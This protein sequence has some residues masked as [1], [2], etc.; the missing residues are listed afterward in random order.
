MK[1]IIVILICV[2]VCCSLLCQ[3]V[4]AAF[5][6]ATYVLRSC[7][8]D[9]ILAYYPGGY[10]Q[11][12]NPGNLQVDILEGHAAVMSFDPVYFDEQVLNDFTFAVNASVSG[13]W[14]GNIPYGQFGYLNFYITY[15]SNLDLNFSDLLNVPIEVYDVYTDLTYTDYAIAEVSS[16]SYMLTFIVDTSDETFGYYVDDNFDHSYVLTLPI[17]PIYSESDSNGFVS[18]SS[19]VL[20]FQ[21]KLSDTIPSSGGTTD[22]DNPDNPETPDIEYEGV[23][24]QSI[25]RGNQLLEEVI[26]NQDTELAFLAV[27]QKIL[28]DISNTTDSIYEGVNDLYLAVS[29]LPYNIANELVYWDLGEVDSAD[30]PHD[31][32]DK[33]AGLEDQLY[34]F[35]DSKVEYIGQSIDQLGNTLNSH[36]GQVS[37]GHELFFTRVFEIDFIRDLVYISLGFGLVAFILRLGRKIQ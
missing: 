25:E 3:P 31:D 4:S 21:I 33:L 24:I 13:Y 11:T 32:L 7:E 34:D 35:S 27:N 17:E 2:V 23:V 8:P 37:S 28:G 9:T 30:I 10:Y 19:M 15:S 1:R 20:D 26:S 12:V 29:D 18:I 16:N 22:P 6:D 5:Y 14:T 36:I